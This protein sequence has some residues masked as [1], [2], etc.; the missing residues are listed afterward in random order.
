ML[1]TFG[2]SPLCLQECTRGKVRFHIVV[3][4]TIQQG[5]WKPTVV[6]SLSRVTSGYFVVVLYGIRK[7]RTDTLRI[8]FREDSLLIET[9]L[10]CRTLRPKVNI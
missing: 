10:E 9:P 8:E 5:C 4:C 2:A 6:F 1:K 3:D 7:E